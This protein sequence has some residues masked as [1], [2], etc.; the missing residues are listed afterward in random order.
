MAPSEWQPVTVALTSFFV[1]LDFFILLTFLYC[2]STYTSRSCSRPHL[3]VK[4]GRD[5]RPPLNFG[6]GEGGAE[7]ELSTAN[8][9]NGTNL[10]SICYHGKREVSAEQDGRASGADE[11]AAGGPGVQPDALHRDLAE[12]PHPGLT[13]SLRA[14][15][16]IRESGKKKGGGIALFV[17]NKWCNPG[18]IHLKEQRC[19]GDIELLAVSIRPY[20]LPRE[21]SHVITQ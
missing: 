7:P 18:H 8:G 6:G 14:D 3:D 1:Y 11:A 5:R 16:D 2:F 9:D 17:N 13:L 12:P 10:P 15:R 21:F 20:Y 19:T 4:L